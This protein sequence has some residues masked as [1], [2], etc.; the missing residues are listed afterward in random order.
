MNWKLWFKIREIRDYLD[1]R[2]NYTIR[3][4]IL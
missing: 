4:K 2:I 3:I 1:E